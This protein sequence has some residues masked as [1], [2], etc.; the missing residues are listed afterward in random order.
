MGGWSES[1]PA[2][3]CKQKNNLC[4]RA[5][6]QSITFNLSF[7][8][9]HSLYAT[10]KTQINSL[11]HAHTH[12]HTPRPLTY[13]QALKVEELRSE[14]EIN[15]TKIHKHYEQIMANNDKAAK[16]VKECTHTH[17]QTYITTM[18]NTQRMLNPN[19]IQFTPCNAQ[20]VQTTET[21]KI[22][23]LE[24][25]EKVKHAMLDTHITREHHQSC[26]EKQV[27]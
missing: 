21:L 5:L 7:T 6:C 16:K 13:T 17:K 25:V 1:T 24:E 12:P 18:H 27:R 19:D 14:A 10:S 23:V 26:I 11:V 3:S 8:S 9:A 15:K 22:R 4:V 20:E 2:R